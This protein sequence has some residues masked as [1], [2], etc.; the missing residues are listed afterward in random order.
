[1]ASDEWTRLDATDICSLDEGQWLTDNVM[2]AVSSVL[3]RQNPALSH[4]LQQIFHCNPGKEFQFNDVQFQGLQFHL[5][6]KSHYVLSSTFERV[7]QIYDSQ[8]KSDIV[9]DDLMR[10]LAQLYNILGMELDEGSY[11]LVDCQQQTNGNDCGLY[12]IA[13][14]VELLHGDGDHISSIRFEE[15][16]MRAHL[17][18]CLLSGIMT[19]FPRQRVILPDVQQRNISGY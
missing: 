11:F 19:P 7:V 6:N 12:A 15:S 14:A 2:D 13:N 8:K 1:M 10:Q 9:E 18:D 5:V 16:Q 4:C 3:K 17:K